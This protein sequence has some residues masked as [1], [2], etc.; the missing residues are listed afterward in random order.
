M[1]LLPRDDSMMWHPI[2]I[3]PEELFMF[4]HLKPKRNLEGNFHIIYF[5]SNLKG[6]K[7]FHSTLSCQEKLKVF[8][9]S[10]RIPLLLKPTLLSVSI[11]YGS[12]SLFCSES[13]LLTP[14][15]RSKFRFYITHLSP[16]HDGICVETIPLSHVPREA[17]VVVNVVLECQPKPSDYCWSINPI[18]DSNGKMNSD[19]FAQMRIPSRLPFVGMNQFHPSNKT[20]N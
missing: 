11:Y 20:T 10:N 9:H 17:C 18:F 14:A 5:I 15:N 8:I 19:C 2:N 16:R 12:Q 6:I 7:N 1:L 3:E 13:I 4:H